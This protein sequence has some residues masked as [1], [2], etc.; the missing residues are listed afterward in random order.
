MILFESLVKN[1]TAFRCYNKQRIDFL[2][3]S[4]EYKKCDV[5]DLIPFLL[6]EDHP[7]LLGNFQKAT[8]LS[9]ISQF[10]YTL[11]LK[12]LIQKYFAH[13][14]SFDREKDVCAIEFLAIIGSAG[15]A[16]FTEESDLDFWVGIET[17]N[18]SPIEL[19]FLREKLNIIEKWANTVAELEV[20]FFIVDPKKIQAN[21]YGGITKESCGTA[22]GNLLKDEFYRTGILITGKLPYFWIMPVGTTMADYHEYIRTI[23]LK[24]NSD[25]EKYIDLGYIQTISQSEYFG[26]ALWQILKGLHSPFKSILKMALLDFYSS[27]SAQPLLC[28]RLKQGIF[29]GGTSEMPDP[30]LFLMERLLDFYSGPELLSVKNFIEK[31]FFIRNLVSLNTAIIRD[32]H[33]IRQLFTVAKKWKW[34]EGDLYHL[35]AFGSWDNAHQEKFRREVI[36]FFMNAYKRIRG[37]TK[38]IPIHI[39]QSDLT[40]V[41]KKIQSFFKLS[42]GKIP[43]EFSLFEGKSVSSIEIEEM[44]GAEKQWSVSITKGNE[45][46]PLF[47]VI[48]SMAHPLL[49]CGWCSING[50]YNGKQKILF[51]QKAHVSEKNIREVMQC[52]RGFFPLGRADDSPLDTLLKEPVISHLLILPNWEN[53]D[54]TMNLESISVFYRNSIGEVFFATHSGV[55][56]ESWLFKEILSKTIGKL[57]WPH[58]TWK[59]HTAKGKIHS[60]RRLGDALGRMIQR[61]ISNEGEKTDLFFFRGNF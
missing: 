36:D 21:D 6:H 30:S 18:Y 22:L 26:A 20:H 58:L 56:C 50:F 31:C 3:A 15:T 44:N 19:E 14:R 53:P 29:A 59:I 12:I 7:K 8:P 28:D 24:G 32:R 42:P 51:K 9:G 17:D 2:R 48:R 40:S 11:E 13:F 54:W 46:K 33:H 45:Q 39:S 38:N 43:F 1:E 60:T 35:M 49:V 37:R 57:N 5:F 16:A 10:S 23:K 4:L 34:N 47:R 25:S 61:L 27:D 52:V 55:S 41:G